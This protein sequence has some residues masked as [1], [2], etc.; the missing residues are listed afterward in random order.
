MVLTPETMMQFGQHLQAWISTTPANMHLPGP[1]LWRSRRYSERP[2][3]GSGLRSS[4]GSYGYMWDY[5]L[6][7]LGGMPRGA[8]SC[9]W[10]QVEDICARLKV[11][12]AVAGGW[13][14]R[15]RAGLGWRPGDSRSGDG[16]GEGKGWPCLAGLSLPG[17]GVWSEAPGSCPPRVQPCSLAMAPLAGM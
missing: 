10:D 17:A 3:C 2:L 1:A 11:E 6:T 13:G 9:L 12:L 5:M 14:C 4:V 16:A 8:D 7:P 15:G